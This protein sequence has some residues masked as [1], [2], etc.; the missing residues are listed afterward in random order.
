MTYVNTGSKKKNLFRG[1]GFFLSIGEIWAILQLEGR[2]KG[3]LMLGKTN[4]LSFT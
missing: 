1:T 3:G 2:L 4:K